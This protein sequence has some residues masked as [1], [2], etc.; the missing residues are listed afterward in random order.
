MDRG[1]KKYDVFLLDE[2]QY[3]NLVIVY[4]NKP[5]FPQYI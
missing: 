5:L 1:F 3:L 2:Y 4:N